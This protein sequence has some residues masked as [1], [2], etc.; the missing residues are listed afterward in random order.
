MG[1]PWM[2]VFEEVGYSEGKGAPISSLFRFL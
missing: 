1:D 2:Q